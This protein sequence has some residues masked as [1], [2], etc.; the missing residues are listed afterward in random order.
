[1]TDIVNMKQCELCLQWWKVKGYH[2]HIRACKGYSKQKKYHNR[3]G[4]RNQIKKRRRKRS[5][6][7]NAPKKPPNGYL[8]FC[9]AH[10]PKIKA[11]NPS[12]HQTEVIIVLNEQ[13]R[14]ATENIKNMYHVKALQLKEDWET[15]MQ[16]YN[17][18]KQHAALQAQ[19]SA[20][21][22]RQFLT[23]SS[24]HSSSS[25]Q[26][27]PTPFEQAVYLATTSQQKQVINIHGTS[28]STTSGID[29][30]GSP[31]AN[32]NPLHLSIANPRK[33]KR[34]KKK[35]ALQ[36]TRP[37]SGFMFFA[38]DKRTDLAQKNKLAK[39]AIGAI[40][41]ILGSEW[42]KLTDDQKRPY[43][44]QSDTDKLR[45]TKQMKEYLSTHPQTLQS[46][47]YYQKA[48]MCRTCCFISA[49][50]YM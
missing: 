46:R 28:T 42:Q 34:R 30:R 50:M 33:R 10:R 19:L 6:D 23:N 41:K 22:S 39:T 11:E 27:S 5:L 36:P 9:A 35:D 8:M 40:G 21:T 13:W 7:P 24:M 12:Y 44:A 38:K 18:Q 15:N 47:A 3:N 37:L 49:Y 43:Q 25:L 45:Y 2:H 14:G 4:N 48:C 20:A 29:P 17:Q 31:R 1:M 26:I 32:K 16:L